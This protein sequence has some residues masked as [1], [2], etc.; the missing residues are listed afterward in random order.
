MRGP[1]WSYGGGSSNR[2][3][4]TPV[5]IA[6]RIFPHVRIDNSDVDLTF[7]RPPAPPA[8]EDYKPAVRKRYCE[9][10]STFPH[11]PLIELHCSGPGHF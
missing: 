7:I 8:L 9:E 1:R 6:S 10:L 2:F 3:D 5:D 11:L 4:P